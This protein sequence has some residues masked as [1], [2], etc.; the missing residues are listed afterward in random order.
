MRVLLLKGLSAWALGGDRTETLRLV[1]GAAGL[2][3]EVALAADAVP[4]ELAGIPH[5]RIDYPQSP[6]VE[7]Q[8]R[9][10]LAVFRPDVVHVI[11]A[12]IRFLEVFARA[13]DDVPWTFT[14]HNLPP[15]ERTFPRLF[16]HPRLYYAAR[17]AL[18]LPSIRLW[19]RFLSRGSFAR[20]ICHSE[21]VAR[22]LVARGCDAS[23][24]VTIPFGCDEPVLDVAAASPFPPGASPR[25]L[26]VAGFAPHKGQLDAV[27]AIARL[28]PE[29]PRLAYRMIGNPRPSERYARFIQREVQQLGLQG[30]VELLENASDATKHAG[31]RDADLY[32]Q[33]SHEEGFCIA[34]LEAATTVPRLIGT[35]TGAM[36]SIAEGDGTAQV[37]R[38][39]DVA[40]LVRAMRTL[41]QTSSPPD[42]VARR[43]QSL[44][45]RY[46]WEA[47]A[48]LH[49]DTYSVIRSNTT[50]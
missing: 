45:R 29:F 36:R 18:A 1:R 20:V 25:I 50:A 34:F 26:T 7:S 27:R 31:L 39:G 12:G 33:P 6:A 21:T 38:P 32:L 15:A 41:L 13:L 28:R 49:V 42:S 43:R 19:S 11:G 4:N 23:K 10:A 9:D 8:V 22:R 16:A 17:N 2:G 5:F 37:V 30:A 40:A 35:D 46:S 48:T 3:C 24:I 44:S 14:A 47:Y